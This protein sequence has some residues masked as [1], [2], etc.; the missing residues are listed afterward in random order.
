MVLAQTKHSI[1][2]KTR[3]PQRYGSYPNPPS[4]DVSVKM[5]RFSRKIVNYMA[6]VRLNHFSDNLIKIHARLRAI[7]A[8][9]ASGTNSSM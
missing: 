3:R 2:S 9:A 4:R 8:I 7:P 5:R 1:T 6:A